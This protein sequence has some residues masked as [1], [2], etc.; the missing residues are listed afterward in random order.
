MTQTSSKDIRIEL[1]GRIIH[2]KLLPPSSVG[3]GSEMCGYGIFAGSMLEMYDD[4]KGIHKK[5]VNFYALE[6]LKRKKCQKLIV[7]V[8]GHICSW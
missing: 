4:S 1:R 5:N 7:I 3:M 2:P 6:A 8:I